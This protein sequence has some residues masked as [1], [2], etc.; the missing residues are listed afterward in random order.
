VRRI[1]LL[2]ATALV[3]LVGAQAADAERAVHIKD[4][5]DIYTVA[6]A[7]GCGAI[8]D[9]FEVTTTVSGMTDVTLVYN[10]GGLLVKVIATSPE[11]VVTYSSP[12]RSF[13]YSLA[14]TEITTFPEGATVGAPAHMEVSGLW[15]RLPGVQPTAGAYI[16]TNFV[17]SDYVSESGLPYLQQTEESTVSFHG[18]LGITDNF[19]E[20][21]CAALGPPA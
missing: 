18:V 15:L 6:Y 8:D 1:M 16:F 2:L 11:A 21:L 20:A 3:A 9:G 5:H 4:F 7:G 12:Y 19:N 17:V 14:L 10:D 13:S